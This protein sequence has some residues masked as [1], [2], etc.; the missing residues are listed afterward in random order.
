MEN[1]KSQNLA[2]EATIKIEPTLRDDLKI[3]SIQCG[4]ELKEL[5]RR[6]LQKFSN[7]YHKS[8]TAFTKLSASL[9][10]DNSN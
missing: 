6:I 10:S 5:T 7:D 1:N 4:V 9:L 8:P 2:K 3:I